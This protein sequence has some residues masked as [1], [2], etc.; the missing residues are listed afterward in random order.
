MRYIAFF[1]LL[2]TTI[3]TNAQEPPRKA[4][5]GA[6]GKFSENGMAVDSVAPATTLAAVGLRK[7]DTIKQLNNV[8]ITAAA[9][10]NT[11]AGNIRTGDNVT[12][13][14]KRAG[15]LQTKTTKALMRPFD[16]LEAAEVV[17]GWAKMNNCSL[18][19]IV[20]KPQ[21]SGKFPAVLLVPGYNCGSVENY[22]QGSYGK[23]IDTWIKAGFAVVTIEKSGMGDSYNCL[24]CSEADLATDAKSFDI[25]YSY[26][27]SLPY[28]DKENMF[29]WG[30]S[31]GGVIAP[32][33]AEKH[34]P[35]GVI[36]FATVFRPWSEF[37]IEMHRV[38]WP[39]DGKSY[40]ETEDRARAMQKIYYEYFRLK[41]SPE[42]LYQ[43]PEYRDLVVSELEY[44]KGDND[45]WGRH[46]RFWQQLDSVDLARSWANVKAPVLS[47]FGGADWIACSELEHELI[48]RTVNSTHPGNATH[49]NIPDVDHLIIQNPDWKTAHKNFSDVAYRNTHFHQG[50]ANITV[51]W[52]KSVMKN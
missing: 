48:V 46:W 47:I 20:R 44:K 39:L 11:T 35:R 29:I 18:R 31:M 13:S 7:G 4:V 43:N 12:V 33:I 6:Y 30:H 28:V 38:Q 25:G 15:K 50:F 49:V 36:A 3:S 45:M 19:T 51:Q 17:Y 2:L 8:T 52:M 1:L 14:Y 9:S 24:P 40:A 21:G 22:S 37:L 23:L 10:Y 5:M 34:T 41:K 42:Q 26:M 27:E 32:L 16:K